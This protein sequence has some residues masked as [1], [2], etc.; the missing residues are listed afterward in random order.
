MP[1]LDDRGRLFGKVNIIDAAVAL[2]L[3]VLIP[4]AYG[5]YRLFRSLPPRIVAAEPARI[6]HGATEIRIRGEHLRPYLRVAVG[7]QFLPLLFESANVGALRLPLLEPGSYDLVLYDEAQELGRV[8][9]GLLID[10]P[11]SI[12]TAVPVEPPPAPAQD[13]AVAAAAAESTSESGA[14]ELFVVGVIRGLSAAT[15]RSLSQT[16]ETLQRQA[17]PWGQ[18]VG[19]APPEPNIEYLRLSLL[20][21]NGTYQVRAVL[22][23]RCAVLH[24]ECLAQKVPLEPGAKVPLDIR[25][26]EVT[27][28]VEELHPTYTD[29]L[30]VVVKSNPGLVLP[31]PEPIT[32]DI[33]PARDALRLSVLSADLKTLPGEGAPAVHV[34]LRVPVV[35]R[36]DGWLHKS[37]PLR[38]GEELVVENP[39]YVIRGPILSIQPAEGAGAAA[40]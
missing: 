26:K 29:Y 39:L 11:A 2:V 37:R 30:E 34:R 5:A 3:C 16:L 6:A 23:L 17:S 1:V 36:G 19:F 22:K 35:K 28:V 24:N 12:S 9:N 25:G 32:R 15:A 31:L 38:V 40:R 7:K 33:F 10:A 18:V 20:V 21:S 14:G 27:F 8:A 13:E 4:L